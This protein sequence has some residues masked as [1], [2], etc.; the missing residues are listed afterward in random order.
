MCSIDGSVRFQT[1]Q[2]LQGVVGWGEQWPEW[3]G[4]LEQRA[5]LSPAL[6]EQ[7]ALLG[8]RDRLVEACADTKMVTEFVV[9]CAEPGGGVEGAEPAH[10]L[11]PLLDAP[12]VLLDP[13][14]H[15]PAGAVMDVGA[16]GLPHRAGRSHVRR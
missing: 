5:H 6:L 1:A 9:G 8:K 11:V 3:L 2:V 7:A 15:V 16:E 12:V 13:V 4:S 14:V 10:G